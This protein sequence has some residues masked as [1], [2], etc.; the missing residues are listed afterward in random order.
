MTF[1]EIITNG[2]VQLALFA[3]VVGLLWY[4]NHELGYTKQ[5]KQK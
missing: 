4:T 2:Y 5:S 3:I 1:L